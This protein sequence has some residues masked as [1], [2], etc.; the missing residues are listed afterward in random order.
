MQDVL[1]KS[2]EELSEFLKSVP[3]LSCWPQ[4]AVAR[5]LENLHR[6]T[7]HAVDQVVCREGQVAEQIYFVLEG[8]FE[9]LRERISSSD[10]L[11][12]ID[13]NY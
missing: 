12:R 13:N 7:Y 6:K 10:V 5:L 8:T 1:H 3:Y 9:I 4:K 11:E 2:H